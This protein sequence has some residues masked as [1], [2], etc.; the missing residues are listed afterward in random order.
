MN[1]ELVELVDLY[2]SMHTC[3]GSER[4]RTEATQK[5]EAKVREIASTKNLAESVL[6]RHVKELF[7]KRARAA[8]KRATGTTIFPD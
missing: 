5:L 1:P 2:E 3:S 8:D 7:F 6:M 4:D